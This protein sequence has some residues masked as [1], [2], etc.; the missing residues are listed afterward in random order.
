M[1][2]KVAFPHKNVNTLSPSYK[3]EQKGVFLYLNSSRWK[4]R[5]VS[6]TWTYL[7]FVVINFSFCFRFLLCFLLRIGKQ[8][9]LLPHSEKQ[10][11]PPK[12]I[13]QTPASVCNHLFS[14]RNLLEISDCDYHWTYKWVNGLILLFL[15]Y[16]EWN[17]QVNSSFASILQNCFLNRN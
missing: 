7:H 16:L 9:F 4:I 6:I 5:P 12:E 11:G 8:S 17:W 2:K 10:S 13:T 15:M 3:E 1:E 14:L